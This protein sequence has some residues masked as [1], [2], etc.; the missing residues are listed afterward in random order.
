[1][2]SFIPSNG[3][4]AAD[5]VVAQDGWWPD[6]SVAAC[7]TLTGL[8]TVYDADRVAAELAAAAIEVNASVAAWR[9]QQPA[10]SLAEI[11]TTTVNGTSALVILYTSAVYCLVRARLLE[12][13]R[14]Y[15]STKQGHDR[16]EALEATAE[17]WR[18]RSTEAL[19]RL[20]GRP[21]VTVELI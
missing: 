17:S 15:D 16:A 18:Q 2:S 6:L 11:P 5:V 12:V 14:D 21:R 20:I 3:S 8:G 4:S 10:P 7:R 13:T 9:A 19:T 1:M